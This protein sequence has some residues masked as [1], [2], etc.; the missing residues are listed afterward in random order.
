MENQTIKGD[1]FDVMQQFPDGIFDAII[2][3]PP[4][5]INLEH[6]DKGV[7][8]PLFTTEVK[9]LLGN[10]FYSFFGQMPTV[11]NWINNANQAGLKY[12]DHIVWAKR[13]TSGIG[14]DLHR[15]HESIY[16]YS[17]NTR[18]YYK[19]EGFYQDIKIP[20]LFT[21]CLN[22][23]TIERYAGEI[24]YYMTH[25]REPRRAKSSSISCNF[26]SDYF[27]ET[28]RRPLRTNFTNLWSFLPHNMQTY[29]KGGK[30]HP[31]AK[32]L[33]LVKRL[34]ELLTPENGLILDPFAGSGTLAIACLETNRRY[35]CIEQDD[36]YFDVMQ[37]RITQWHNDQ[38]NKTGT[39]ELPDGIERIAVQETGQLNLF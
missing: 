7:D 4:Y 34:V 18:K 12:K 33:D 20:L 39:H 24:R 21:H 14:L 19:K 28:N 25:G 10:G 15:T 38:L 8:I 16:I 9:R 26:G 31:T 36:K 1:C 30:E 2:T 17:K 23:E 22:W 37:N 35:V 32:P 5:G 6:W 3:D 27:S 13:V 11:I 29:N